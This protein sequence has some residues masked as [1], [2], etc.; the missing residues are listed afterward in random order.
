MGPEACATV[1]M[2]AM[3]SGKPV[4]ATKIGG[5]PDL[6][7]TGVTGLL[8]PPG[9][10]AALARS[11]QRLL[12]QPEVVARMGTASLARVE[13]LKAGSVVAR[14]EGV[15]RDVLREKRANGGAGRSPLWTC[16]KFC[17]PTESG[18]TGC[19]GSIF[20]WSSPRP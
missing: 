16:H 17:L 10:P 20:C 8:V 1:V 13:R 15:Y 4:I 6:V 7:D 18:S 14:I 3:A 9:D 11:I 12:A 5:M 19:S 2:E